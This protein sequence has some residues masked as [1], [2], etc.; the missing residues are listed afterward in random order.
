MLTTL[1]TARTLAG[2]AFEARAGGVV[3]PLVLDAVTGLG[4]GI[5]ADGE[6]FSLA[7]SGPA[8]PALSQGTVEILPA[9]E[10]GEGTPVFLVPVGRQGG[11]MLYEAIFN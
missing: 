10:A 8:T 9:G 11:R 4:Q 6:S 7:F 1:E 5:R 3:V 2:R